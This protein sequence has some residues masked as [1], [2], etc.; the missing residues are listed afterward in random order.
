MKNPFANRSLRVENIWT[1]ITI[2]ELNEHKMGSLLTIIID[3]KIFDR[4]KRSNFA[5]LLD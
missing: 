4:F 2:D 5:F 1:I 3:I